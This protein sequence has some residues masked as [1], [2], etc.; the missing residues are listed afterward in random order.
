[1]NEENVHHL[2]ESILKVLI[3]ESHVPLPSLKIIY[4][5]LIKYILKICICPYLTN[6]L[7]FY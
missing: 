2:L 5:H 6:I 3:L 7:N 4:F 1:M